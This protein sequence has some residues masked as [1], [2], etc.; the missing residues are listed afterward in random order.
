MGIDE[1]RSFFHAKLSHGKEEHRPDRVAIAACALLLELAHADD[2]FG[3]EERDRILRAVREDLKV[4][5]DEVLEVLRLAEEERRESVD[6]YQF[7]RLVAENFTKEQ[8]LR[9]IEAIWGVVY[10]DGVLTAAE[11]QLA[12]RIAELLGFQHPEVQAL[13]ERVASR[14]G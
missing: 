3:E 1:I 12:R 11:N 13:K 8:R 2:F 7:T 9:L 14:R 6:L 5:E 10:S 4:P